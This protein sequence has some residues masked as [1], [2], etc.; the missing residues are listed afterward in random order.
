[1]RT[2]A[3]PLTPMLVDSEGSSLGESIST[4]CSDTVSLFGSPASEVDVQEKIRSD[5]WFHDGNIVLLVGHVAFKVHRGQLERHSEVFRDILSIPQPTD[6]PKQ[7]GCPMIELFDCPT[8]VWYLLKAL[9]D[10]L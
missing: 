2:P 10:G 1:M 5:F 8:D 4:V 9:Y 6:S 7:D 3:V